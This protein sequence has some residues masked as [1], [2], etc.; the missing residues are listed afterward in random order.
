MVPSRDSGKVYQVH[1]LNFCFTAQASTPPALA[2]SDDLTAVVIIAGKYCTT[3]I[4]VFHDPTNLNFTVG[5]R[6]PEV[7]LGLST[8]KIK[9]LS[10]IDQ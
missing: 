10:E 8:G 6:I 1:N 5:L 7:H 9:N 2:A 4:D 3:T